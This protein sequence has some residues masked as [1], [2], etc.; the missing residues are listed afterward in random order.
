[1]DDISSDGDSSDTE[2]VS[3]ARLSSSIPSSVLITDDESISEMSSEDAT[4]SID[5]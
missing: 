5:S 1:M 3:G 4:A 2:T